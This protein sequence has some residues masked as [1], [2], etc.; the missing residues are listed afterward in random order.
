MQK[1]KN[2]LSKLLNDESV[3]FDQS[4]SFI[5]FVR[6]LQF[7]Q[8]LAITLQEINNNNQLKDGHFSIFFQILKLSILD[9]DLLPDYIGYITTFFNFIVF[10]LFML[11]IVYLKRTLQNL[12]KILNGYLA[13]LP[14]I[15]CFLFVSSTFRSFLLNSKTHIVI[16]IWAIFD[17]SLIFLLSLMSCI[18][19]RNINFNQSTYTRDQSI[20]K[21]VSQI[22]QFATQILYF[23]H[24]QE[25]ILI[26]KQL[27]ALMWIGLEQIDIYLYMPYSLY[28]SKL[29]FTLNQIKFGCNLINLI[30]NNLSLIIETTYSQYIYYFIFSSICFYLGETCYQRL[31]Y[32]KGLDTF[33]KSSEKD[34]HLQIKVLRQFQVQAESQ[35]TQTEKLL[36]IGMVNQHIIHCSRKCQSLDS[37]DVIRCIVNYQVQTKEDEHL[38]LFKV[39][40]LGFQNKQYSQSLARLKHYQI[41]YKP[42]L[43]W[44]FN[45]IQIDI[46]NKLRQE[47]MKQQQ[48]QK[49]YTQD[50]QSAN[51]SSENLV[52][53]DIQ[54]DKLIL[55]LRKT[56]SAKLD[57]W[58]KQLKGFK[59]IRQLQLELIKLAEE[60]EKLRRKFK[61]IINKDV[62]EVNISQVNNLYHLRMLSLYYSIIMNDQLHSFLCEKQYYLIYC[63]EQTLQQDQLNSIALVHDKV[64]IVTVSLVKSLGTILNSNKQQLGHIFNYKKVEE[65]QNIFHL[66]QLMPDFIA[67]KHNQ[68]LSKFLIK[69]DSPF[70]QEFRMI[71]GKTKENFIFPLQLKLANDFSYEDDYVIKGIFFSGGKRYDY[72]LF[73]QNGRILG[74][75]KQIYYDLFTDRE[76]SQIDLKSLYSFCFLYYFI[77]DLFEIT[78]RCYQRQKDQLENVN[79]QEDAIFISQADIK[80]FHENFQ[81]QLKYHLRDLY[82]IWNIKKKQS[83]S[84][85]QSTSSNSKDKNQFVE[86]NLLNDEYAKFASEFVN[87]NITQQKTC[88][89]RFTLYFQKSNADGFFIMQISDYRKHDLGE[90]ATELFALQDVDSTMKKS[91]LRHLKDFIISKRRYGDQRALQSVFTKRKMYSKQLVSMNQSEILMTQQLSST[92]FTPKACFIK[93]E[94]ALNSEMES[95]QE[96]R[97]SSSEESHFLDEFMSEEDS[98]KQNKRHEKKI[99]SFSKTNNF[100]DNDQNPNKSQNSSGLSKVSNNQSYFFQIVFKQKSKLPKSILILWFI[101]YSVNLI[102]IG[103]FGFTNYHLISNYHESQLQAQQFMGPLRFNRYFCKTLSLSWIFILNNYGILNNS[104]YSIQQSLYQTSLLNQFVFANLTQLYPIFIQ[105]ESDGTLE[106]ITIQYSVDNI[107]QVEF[108]RLLYFMEEVIHYLVQINTYD[109]SNYKEYINRQYIDKMFLIEQNL[110]EI[111]DIDSDL[112]IQLKENFNTLQ[113]FESTIFVIEHLIH[114]AI[115]FLIMLVQLI[116]WNNIEQQNRNLA[117]L[118]G[119]IKDSEIETEILRAHAVYI[120]LS[121]YGGEDSWKR[122]NYYNFGF[123][124]NVS[125]YQPKQ[126]VS[127]SQQLQLVQ[128]SQKNTRN[129]QTK[130]N[131]FSHLFKILTFVLIYQIYLWGGYAIFNG[132][133][134]RL[135]PL[136]NLLNDFALFSSKL[137]NLASAA[138][139]IKTKPILF[140]KLKSLNIYQENELL[141]EGKIIKLF[142]EFYEDVNLSFVKLYENIIKDLSLEYSQEEVQGLLSSDICIYLSDYLPFCQL[143]ITNN[144]QDFIQ[145]YGTYVDQDDNSEYLAHGI[146]TLVTT[147]QQFY[148]QNFANEISNGQ[149]VNNTE[150]IYLLINSSEFNVI[151]LS[152]FRDTYFC[153]IRFLELVDGNIA[154]IKEKDLDVL[155]LYY[156]II[157]VVYLILFHIYYSF[158]INRN[159]KEMRNIKLALIAIP[160]FQLTSDPVI[161]ILKRYQ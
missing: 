118:V 159:V 146:L 7:L 115:I 142:D 73:D 77:P 129:F 30:L 9:I 5:L 82:C 111:I 71:F 54:S 145:K 38:F 26:L 93:P 43:S 60:L 49:V 39:R 113:Q 37:S 139:I 120:A 104:Q 138:L 42:E 80:E 92:N 28:D 10:L 57:I 3:C 56:L 143:K 83:L 52:H 90:I 148:Q 81:Q 132:Q 133:Q 123:Q 117:L 17:V 128:T 47:I 140:Q 40:Y 141:D 63:Y 58:R 13:L 44:Y 91:T 155:L 96:V 24:D 89:L 157:I 36:Q 86:I 87:Q 27:S 97:N 136:S 65:F 35:L 160:H 116:Q 127:I 112:L 67:S 156:D 135:L 61:L 125:F 62:Y 102:S 134:N 114:T 59:T 130:I 41:K 103:G 154:L 14:Q 150:E 16:Y 55:N 106:N 23:Y 144:Q 74:I 51:L 18:L 121:V 12:M 70:F 108:T 19:F 31:F 1:I 95:V 46:S 107:E 88:F 32:A 149:Y 2:N 33:T 100:S 109:Y 11:Q 124:Q 153:F 85:K 105:M 78:K 122:F 21:I 66:N 94:I 79:L 53:L 99:K 72:I 137:D 68:M 50:T 98:K 20:M 76:E 15:M 64:A 110:P 161:N 8:Y 147:I 22:F 152:H 126:K 119:R 25:E 131:L 101:V 45:L 34:Q 4:Y 75:T 84:I 6:M 48:S 151:V 69:G 158:W 29:I